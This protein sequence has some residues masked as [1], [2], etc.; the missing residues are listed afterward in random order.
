MWDDPGTYEYYIPLIWQGDGPNPSPGY[1]TRG[2]M[3]G[4]GGIP[5]S[6]WGGSQ[7]Y[8]GGGG[9]TLPAYIN[10]YN[11]ISAENSPAEMSLELN[12]NSQGQ[13]AFLLDVTLT[14]DITT[15]NNQIV[16][17]LT[18][19][20]EPGQLPD[21]FASVI[22]YEQETFDLTTAGQTGSYELAI[23]MAANW[24]LTKMKAIAMIQT[25]GGNHKIHQ[26]SI[27]NFTGLLPMFT[28]NLN[29][30]PAYLGVQ[31]TSTSFP[32]TGIDSWEWDFDGDGVFDSTLENPYHMYT[33]PGVY[34]VTLRI[35][36]GGETAETTAAGLINVTDGTVAGGL[37][38]GTWLPEFNPY[39]I[40]GDVD[41]AI[42][43]Q[44][45]I[46][47]GVELLFDSGTQLTVYGEFIADALTDTDDPIIITSNSEWA[48]I[49]FV[50]SQ[51]NN[52]ISGCEISNANGTAISIENGSS[53]DI[54]GNKIFNNTSSSLG[55]AI[56]VASSDDVFISQNYIANNVSTNLV[57]GIGAIASAIE[58]SNNVIVNNT[59]TYGA[60]SLKNGSDALIEN[61]TIAN[62]LSTSGTSYLFFL[63][64]AIPT[65]NNNIII[66]NG[67]IFFAPFGD[68]TVTYTCLTGGFTG[69]GNIDENPLFTAPTEGDGADYDGL[70]A[71]WTLLEGS[72][73]IDAG[74]PDAAYNDPDG[75]QNDMGA[76]GGPNALASPTGTNE[77]IIT[78]VSHSSISVYPNPF[79]PQTTVALN[80]TETDKLHP[81]TIG[82]Y[83]VKGQLVKTLVDNIVVTNTNVIWNGTDNS[84]ENTSSG[85]YFIKL[86]TATTSV[87]KKILL[88]K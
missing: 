80:M 45:V 2:S 38:S 72:P 87:G 29:E 88:L 52:L 23:N 17:V 54:I 61:N 82:I 67:T 37:L 30:G 73:C 36:V 78:V 35:T 50:G 21:Y 84:G 12:T 9:S 79:N 44:L 76:Y 1:S 5:H 59:G 86:Q 39:T 26:A 75:S 10:L 20:W 27:T 46:Q 24:D 18:H 8:I 49:R 11:S 19:D 3:Y 15:T 41:I 74:D 55:A 33:T 56:D 43:D 32:Q 77:N 14:G 25:F 16:W 4:V 13:L 40:S 47:P 66:D 70:N 68:P 64:N 57:G 63:F 69:E 58:I 48:G 65:L 83:N 53:V 28:T 71:L 22:L 6:Q 42:S 60:F 81:V 85:M 7:N 34:D 31:F 62:N 51:Q